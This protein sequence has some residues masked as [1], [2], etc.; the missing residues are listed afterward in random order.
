MSELYELYDLVN[1]VSALKWR[2]YTT[3]KKAIR[4]KQPLV[5]TAEKNED[6]KTYIVNLYYPFLRVT[7]YFNEIRDLIDYEITD[8][9]DVYNTLLGIYDELHRLA[10]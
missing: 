2:D 7:L 8:I 4:F 5:I 9:L 3:S 10:R 6:N 1:I